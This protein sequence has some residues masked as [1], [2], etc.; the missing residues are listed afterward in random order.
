MLSGTIWFSKLWL[1]ARLPFPKRIIWLVIGLIKIRIA[2]FEQASTE[3]IVGK[4]S[5]NL[6]RSCVVVVVVVVY[7]HSSQ[8]SKKMVV[9]KKQNISSL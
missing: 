1:L 2:Y 8:W 3:L 6:S 5:L 7:Q 9:E 4:S